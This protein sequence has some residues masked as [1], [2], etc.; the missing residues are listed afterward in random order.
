MTRPVAHVSRGSR[1]GGSHLATASGAV[2]ALVVSLL[3][4]VGPLAAPARA[5]AGLPPLFVKTLGG[6]QHSEIYPGGL[7]TSAID[8]TLVVADTGNNQIVKY[9][10]TGNQIWRIG[11]WGAGVGQFDNPRDVGVDSLGN[12]LVIDTRNSRIVKL[13]KDG[14]WLSTYDG[15]G[16]S[17]QINFPVGGSVTN[18]VLYVADTGRKR[19]LAVSTT[20]WSVVRE[21]IKN[22]PNGSNT[23]QSFFDIRDADAD[24]AG[25]I[26][27]AGYS[28]NQI[29][30]VTPGGACS[31]WGSTGGGS[32]Q[33]RT[34]YGVR[35]AHDPVLDQDVLFVADALNFRVQEFT[36]N[37]N[38][39]T[40]FGV[41]GTP[42]QQG[43]ITTMRRVAVATDGTGDVWTA[44]LWGFQVERYDRGQ[45][46]SYDWAQ[47]IGAPLGASSDT[48]VF[49]EPRQIGI[50]PD[51]IL[52]MI[53]TVHHRFVRMDSDGHIQ[54]ICG[55]RASEGSTLGKFNWPRGL[56]VDTVTGRDLG[57]RHE[58]EPGPDHQPGL[59]RSGIRGHGRRERSDSDE[60]A[61][62]AR[63]PRDRSEGVH[64]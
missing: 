59:Q 8:N 61:V 60:L 56:K 36:L 38:Y 18:N 31:F 3:T 42:G 30:K 58:A 27:V 7:E 4:V 53:D 1:R 57:R 49:H 32:G 17:L 48:S 37:G 23:C 5:D 26:Y 45:G 47:S 22:D 28:F 39:L 46:V 21:V 24:S 52:N 15:A 2:I 34:P 62:R 25:N 41:E 54:Q 63:H 20:D 9:D 11:S 40:Q 14:S 16:T 10:Q 19:V 55:E 12:V 51:G 29:A 35:V 33:F 64:R 43:T 6:P 13:D 50:G 44:D